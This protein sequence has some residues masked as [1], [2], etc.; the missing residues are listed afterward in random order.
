MLPNH[1]DRRTL[2]QNTTKKKPE[3]TIHQITFY[4]EEKKKNTKTKRT[5]VNVNFMSTT[6][7]FNLKISMNLL[8]V[9]WKP[10]KTIRQI[11]LFHFESFCLLL[12][13]KL[14]QSMYL[15]FLCHFIFISTMMVI[16]SRHFLFISIGIICIDWKC[17]YFCVLH[18][19][20]QNTKENIKHPQR[21]RE[22]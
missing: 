22:W 12:S 21:E 5:E 18:L 1:V 14:A 3:W 13:D 17:V 15:S 2:K 9:H 4:W 7:T 10:W 8:C 6:M 16:A 20:E 19:F 11:V